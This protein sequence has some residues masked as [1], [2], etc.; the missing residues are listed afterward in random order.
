MAGLSDKEILN[1][2]KER[3]ANYEQA[4]QAKQSELRQKKMDLFRNPSN[5]QIQR[6]IVKLEKQIANL[7]FYLNHANNQIAKSE[8]KL[9]PSL[10]EETRPKQKTEAQTSYQPK[11]QPNNKNLKP[12]NKIDLNLKDYAKK[13]G[14]QSNQSEIDELIKDA[15]NDFESRESKRKHAEKVQS[16]MESDIL[17]SMTE[18]IK[19]ITTYISIIDKNYSSKSSGIINTL[20]NLKRK[21]GV[22]NPVFDLKRPSNTLDIYGGPKYNANNKSKDN[23]FNKDTSFEQEVNKLRN[24]VLEDKESQSKIKLLRQTDQ[25]DQSAPKIKTVQVAYEDSTRPNG[26]KIPVLK[27]EET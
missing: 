22:K 26:K 20:E 6:D 19:D 2:L 1:I 16:T 11:E 17:K 7:D 12:E 18:D 25:I 14:Y 27:I 4:K 9:N 8:S 24:N 23:I 13:Q 3:K 15:E 21:Q 5:V 10:E